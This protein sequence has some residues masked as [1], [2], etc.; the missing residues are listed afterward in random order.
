MSKSV[1]L[2]EYFAKTQGIDVLA[3]TLKGSLTPG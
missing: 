2:S 3:F 1:K